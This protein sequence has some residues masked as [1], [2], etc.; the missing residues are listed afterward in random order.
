MGKVYMS[1]KVVRR[2]GLGG[3]CEYS[4]RGEKY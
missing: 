3:K 4:M 2:E 1:S